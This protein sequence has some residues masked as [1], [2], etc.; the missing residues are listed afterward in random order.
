MSKQRMELSGVKNLELN[1]VDDD[2]DLDLP[3]SQLK[4]ANFVFFIIAYFV[5]AIMCL[6]LLLNLLIALMG[7]TYSTNQE[8]ATLQWRK[9]FARMVL[10]LELQAELLTRL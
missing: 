5:F 2:Y 10:R 4:Q 8:S 9:D 1:L 6:V 7:D 3:A